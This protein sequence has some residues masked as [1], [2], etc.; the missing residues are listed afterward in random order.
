MLGSV[1]RP[2]LHDVVGDYAQQ[3]FSDSDRQRAH[4]RMVQIVRE[5]RPAGGWEKL[6]HDPLSRYVTYEIGFH[7]ENAWDLQSG[8][9]ATDTEALSWLDDFDR[10]QDVVPISTAFV[11]GLGRTTILARQAEQA[12]Q[13]WKAALRWCAVAEVAHAT[14]ADVEEFRRPLL[15]SAAALDRMLPREAS[16][17]DKERLELVLMVRILQ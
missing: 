1:D 11:L 3:Q 2:Q 9:W 17:T 15:A 7:I 6:L 13:F 8:D 10:R 12:S 5:R 16:S 14:E 4:R